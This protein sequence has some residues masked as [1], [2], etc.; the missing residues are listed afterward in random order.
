MRVHVLGLPEGPH[1]DVNQLLWRC[2][3]GRRDQ[4]RAGGSNVAK[5]VGPGA[6]NAGVIGATFHGSSPA[7]PGIKIEG[8]KFA[9]VFEPRPLGGKLVGAWDAVFEYNNG[10]TR[11]IRGFVRDARLA[12]ASAT[13]QPAKR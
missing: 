9:G 3:G 10:V 5:I 1:H 7:Q 4:D 2:D 12:P 6:C 8:G 11:P 13:A